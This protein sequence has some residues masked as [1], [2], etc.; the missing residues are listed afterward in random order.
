MPNIFQRNETNYI[1][2]YMPKHY[3][4]WGSGIKGKFGR[5]RRWE[6]NIKMTADVIKE[7]KL[8]W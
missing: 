8:G 2:S 1:G 3:V 6:D 4:S 5:R 7:G